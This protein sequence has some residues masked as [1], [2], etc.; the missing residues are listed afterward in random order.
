MDQ[1]KFRDNRFEEC[2]KETNKVFQECIK[3]RGHNDVNLCIIQQSYQILNCGPLFKPYQRTVN[4]N[5]ITK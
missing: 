4:I 3:N 1:S 2:K 5:D